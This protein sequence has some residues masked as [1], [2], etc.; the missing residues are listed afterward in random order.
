MSLPKI[1][2]SKRKFRDAEWFEVNG[3]PGQRY[4]Q[5]MPPMGISGVYALARKDGTA[6]YV[7]ESHSGRLRDTLSRHW[8][9]WN[10]DGNCPTYQRGT[11]QV[12]WYRTHAR[13]TLDFEAY[14]IEQYRPLD[15]EIVSDFEDDNYEPPF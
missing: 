12:A 15:N 10:C 1:Q 9:E 2:N 7:G 4:P 8:R 11:I 3:K 14:L 5:E 6:V 13:E